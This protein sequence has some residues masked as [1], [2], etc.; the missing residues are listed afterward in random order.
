MA[1]FC[2]DRQTWCLALALWNGQDPILKERLFGLSGPEG[3]HGEDAK[4][5]WWYLDA[6]PTHSWNSW[7]YHYPQR[8]FPYHELVA[9]SRSRGRREPEYE[10]LDTGVFDQDR[11]WVVEVVYAKADPEDLLM[12]VRVT[13]QGRPPL[14]RAEPLAVPQGRHQRLRHHRP[15]HRQSGAT[16]H[17]GRTALRPHRPRWFDDGDPGAPR[18]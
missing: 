6:T 8:E 9:T 12:L 10:L 16:R 15:G 17:E 14:G 4:E 18:R 1:G 11:F 13:N 5:Y 7:R 3:N 2:D